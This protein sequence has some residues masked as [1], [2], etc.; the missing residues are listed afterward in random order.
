MIRMTSPSSKIL[1]VSIVSL[2][3]TTGA[4]MFY[5]QN[6]KPDYQQNSKEKIYSDIIKNI[7]SNTNID[8]YYRDPG[9]N[10][11]TLPT[12]QSDED[13]N[14]FITNQDDNKIKEKSYYTV[15]YMIQTEKHNYIDTSFA[16]NK[17]NKQI[18]SSIKG[19]PFSSQVSLIHNDIVI[20]NNIPVDWAGSIVFQNNIKLSGHV[21]VKIKQP[22]EIKICHVLQNNMEGRS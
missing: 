22:S 5:H 10:V 6:G 11:Y 14:L 3:V 9:N 18:K 7:S 8:V 21:C 17:Q 2:C 1:I 20:E 15:N 4:L 12:M 19:L 13:G 16:V